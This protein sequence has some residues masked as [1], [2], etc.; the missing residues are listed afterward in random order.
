MPGLQGVTHTEV[1]D[2]IIE[3]QFTIQGLFMRSEYDKL[4]RESGSASAGAFMGMP[5][6]STNPEFVA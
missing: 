4:Y 3:V 2:L 1:S 5:Q 6:S